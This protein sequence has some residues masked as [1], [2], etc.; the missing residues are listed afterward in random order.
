MVVKAMKEFITADLLIKSGYR[1]VGNW[2]FHPSGN[3][4]VNLLSNTIRSTKPYFVIE[5]KDNNIELKLI[6][7]LSDTL[8]KL[9]V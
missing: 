3:I 5:R 2:Y 6:N 4:S 8:F 7:D 9:G 1:K